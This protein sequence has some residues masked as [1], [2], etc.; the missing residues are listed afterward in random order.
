MLSGQGRQPAAMEFGNDT[1]RAGGS[2]SCAG[3]AS[4][5]GEVYLSSGYLQSGACTLA[6]YTPTSS[7]TRD[8]ATRACNVRLPLLLSRFLGTVILE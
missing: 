5:S 8:V 6:S 3:P 4:T 2:G 7:W 1:C